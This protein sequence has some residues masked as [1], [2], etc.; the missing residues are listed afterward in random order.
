MFH[1][2]SKW[3]CYCRRQNVLL[4]ICQ[5]VAEKEVALVLEGRREWQPNFSRWAGWS[6][7]Q[8]DI[9]SV[10]LEF[11][12]K[13]FDYTEFAVKYLDYPEFVKYL[14]YIKG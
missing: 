11:A 10:Q 8:V 1:A 14:H 4:S 5:D 12:V 6:L 3:L 2:V 13:Y 7:F 9:N